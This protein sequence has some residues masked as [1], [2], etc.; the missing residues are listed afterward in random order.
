[1]IPAEF[2]TTSKDSLQS[3]SGVKFRDFR[4]S[5]EP[6]FGTVWLHIGLAYLV[7]VLVAAAL[8]NLTGISISISIL[9][10]IIG[11]GLFGY[12]IAFIQLFF[13][14]AAHFNLAAEK[15]TSDVLANIFVGALV[16]QDIRNYRPIHWGHHKWLGSTMD[17]EQTYF[18]PLNTKFLIESLLGIKVLSVLAK[19]EK[20]LQ[21]ENGERK[22]MIGSQLILGALI[23]G[24]IVLGSLY[25]HL[26]ELAAA[27]TIGMLIV[28]PFFASVRQV[29]EHRDEHARPD[30]DYHTIAHGIINRMFG[31]GVVADT[32]GGAGFNRHLL[33]HWD[34]QVS[35]TRLKDLEAYLMETPL[36]GALRSRQTTYFRTFVKLFNN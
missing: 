22:S 2:A 25:A 8:V 4:K 15:K 31:D 26:W 16:G 24:A 27:W 14:E 7:L 17:T 30:V 13:H 9:S 5:L 32:L 10:V 33:H 20:N 18:D 11:A 28:F 12:T 34:P 23:N 6:R 19:R 1:M 29:L 3:S 21:A 36:A 35:Y